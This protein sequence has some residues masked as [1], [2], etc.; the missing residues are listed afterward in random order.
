[1]NYT[2]LLTWCLVKCFLDIS[3]HYKFIAVDDGQAWSLFPTIYTMNVAGIIL[4]MRPANGRRRYNVTLFFI[5]WA[6]AQNDPLQCKAL[7][8]SARYMSLSSAICRMACTRST[9]KGQ[10]DISCILP[11]LII[12][13]KYLLHGSLA[14]YV[15]CGLRMRRECRERF[16][17]DRG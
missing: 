8:L 15:N 16:P 9:C 12:T 4:C 5:G 17:L 2:H 3:V 10:H 11:V 14:R 1:M 6:H 7:R 13:I